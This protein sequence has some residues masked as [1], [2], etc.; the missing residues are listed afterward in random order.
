ME[1]E[2]LLLQYSSLG[3]HGRGC[4]GRLRFPN[5]SVN[6]SLDGIEGRAASEVGCN[7]VV[8]YER[9]YERDMFAEALWYAVYKPDLSLPEP[10]GE[11]V[12]W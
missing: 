4:S 8:G 1:K 9:V 3:V 12:G 7:F 11:P 5:P 10:Y 6:V 2:V